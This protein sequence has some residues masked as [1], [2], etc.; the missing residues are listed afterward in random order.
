MKHPE[1]FLRRR[2][3]L[4]SRT[5]FGALLVALSIHAAPA[6]AQYA[7]LDSSN[8]AETSA[9]TSTSQNQL[10]ELSRIRNLEESQLATLGEFG[11]LGSLFGSSPLGGGASGGST[12]FY[13]NMQNF[14]FDPCTINLCTTGD[15]PVGTTDL[16]EAR[17]WA[18]EAY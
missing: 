14:A 7:V 4:R 2:A 1:F 17:S 3:G 12:D 10:V 16:E 8:L 11:S 13:T 5:A 9:L 15:A 6:M 18:Y